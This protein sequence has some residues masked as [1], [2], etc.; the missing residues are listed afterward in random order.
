[1]GTK[2]VIWGAGGHALVV[3]DAFRSLGED[4]EGF[5]D[6]VNRVQEGARL[7]GLPVWG[8]LQEAI[9]GCS[10]DHIEI[11]LGFGNCAARGRLIQHLDGLGVDLRTVIH[12]SAV[13]SP[14][15]AIGRGVYIGPY[16]VV[17][18][19]CVIGD[20]VILNASSSI[21]HECHVGEAVS[22]CPAVSAGGKTTIG[23]MSWIG[24]GSTLIDKISVG[25]RS[26]VGAGSVVVNDLPGGVLAYG[27]PARVIREMAAEF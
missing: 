19:K 3:A 23:E 16:A 2:T 5:I 18:A 13:V 12:A 25:A 21:C 6:T 17:E 10:H 9:C 27:V 20:G 8:S 4:I 11:A 24:I 26:Y 1:M 14:S 22:V 7:D 15:A